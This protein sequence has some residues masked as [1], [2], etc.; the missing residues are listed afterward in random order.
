MRITEWLKT[1]ASK[2]GSDLYLSTGAPPCAKFE[3][4]L[5]PIASD[6]L[7]PGE[8]KEIAY[9]IMDATQQAEFEEELEMNLATSIPGYGRFRVNIFVQRNE[10]A[11]VARNIVA[12]IPNWQDLGLPTI[13]T[14]VVMRKRGLMLFVGATGSG[15]STS[16]AALIDY[17]NSNSSGHIVTI[18]DPVEYVHSHKQSI[19]NQREV[20]VD[21]RSWHNAL[22]NTLRQAPDVIL[23]GEIRDRETMEHAIAFAET[24]HLCISTLHA[25]NANQALDRIINFFPEE[26]RHQLLMDL[27][28]NLQAIVSQRLIPTLEGKR[29]AAIEVLLGTPMVADLILRGEV[30]GIK[31]VMQ[32]SENVG[33]KTFDTALFELFQEGKIGED[34]ALRNA[35]SPNNVRLKIKFARE[36]GIAPDSSSGSG[37]P[38][39]LSLETVEEEEE[40]EAGGQF[41]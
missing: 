18:E 35:D 2:N 1:L 39:S 25:N 37:T 38:V 7:N 21:T 3:G 36:D 16:L 8:I 5:Q 33:M 17:R 26:R 22:K 34:D 4:Q 13:L 29:C 9:E 41:F 23:I 12:D 10:V 27:S 32:K 19:I 20:G 11:I 6:I 24:G 15:K 30:D 31:E 28:L 40:E 14:D